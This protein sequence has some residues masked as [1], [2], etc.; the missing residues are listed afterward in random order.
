ESDA[1]YGRN[2][3]AKHINFRHHQEDD[4]KNSETIRPIDFHG[5]GQFTTVNG[6]GFANKSWKDMIQTEYA[7]KELKKGVPNQKNSF[8]GTSIFC[9]SRRSKHLEDS[10]AYQV[11]SFPLTDEDFHI[12]ATPKKIIRSLQQSSPDSASVKR[13]AIIENDDD[14]YE[15]SSEAG[16]PE[17]DDLVLNSNDY[18]LS[19]L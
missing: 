16:W 3:N 19:S 2:G 1:Q 15:T 18:D 12:F 5:F 7:K 10:A 17:M 14:K 4:L 13:Q 8:H 6:D 9:W 11:S